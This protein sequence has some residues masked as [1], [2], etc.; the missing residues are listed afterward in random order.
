MTTAAYLINR[1]P[2]PILGYQSPYAKLLKI[3]PDYH[4]LKCFGCLC[5]PWIKAYANHKLA[6]KSAMCIFVGY[7]ADQHAYLCLDP[8]T[9]RIYTS[10][11]VKFVE[12]E[13]SYSSLIPQARPSAKQPVEQPTGQ[14]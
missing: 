10:R 13:F 7:S 12:S 3:N 14:L 4:K 9:G 11:H 1:L 2:T 8:T 6:P 5:F